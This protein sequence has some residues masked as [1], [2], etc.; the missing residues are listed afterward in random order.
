MTKLIHSIEYNS[1]G[2]IQSLKKSVDDVI[3]RGA[4]S[5]MLFLAESSLSDPSSLNEYLQTITTPVI[6][7]VFPQIIHGHKHYECGVLVCGITVELDVKLIPALSEGAEQCQATLIELRDWFDTYQGF[8]IFV[9]GLSANVDPF[10]DILYDQLGPGKSVAGGGAGSLTLEQKPCVLSNQGLLMDTAQI[11]GLAN[12]FS[13]GVRH[14]WQK[15][16]GPFLVTSTDGNTINTLDYRPAFELYK[17]TIE[18]LSD[19]RFDQEDFFSIAKTFP[20]GMEKLDQEILIRDPIS[21]LE[22]GLVCVG[23]V[24][25]NT[26]VYIMQGKPE[27]LID[28][29]GQAASIVN[30]GQK[31]APGIDAL[32]FDCVSRVLFLEDRFEEELES[33]LNNLAEETDLV[34]A[35]TLGE[36]TSSSWGPLQFLNKTTVVCGIGE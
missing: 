19:S 18:A 15:V 35:L 5:I 28:S 3:A 33:I 16:A 2:S 12:K 6:G 10:V 22:N 11:V 21:V 20:F 8:L 32:L 14:G 7:G 4:K 17:E 25:E 1:D 13:I 31:D 24:P 29:S 30:I 26:L 34:G 23:Q 27:A 9:D 36:I